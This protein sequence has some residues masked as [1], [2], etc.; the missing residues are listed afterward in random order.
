MSTRTYVVLENIPF[1]HREFLNF[2][3]V[4]IYFAKNQHCLAKLV[5]FLKAIVLELCER[6]KSFLVK[7]KVLQSMR[8]DSGF[9]IAPNWP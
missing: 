3:N 1:Q 6:F 4:S 8:P 5:P 2:A 7:I 9:R